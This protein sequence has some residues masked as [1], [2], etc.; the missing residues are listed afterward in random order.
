MAS[1]FPNKIIIVQVVRLQARTIAFPFFVDDGVGDDSEE[2]IHPKE[3][4]MRFDSTQSEVKK[5]KDHHCR[6]SVAMEKI[7]GEGWLVGVN[8]FDYGCC[9]DIGSEE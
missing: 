8:I 3:Y 7:L 5:M 1:C 6:P 9:Y 2:S 4:K